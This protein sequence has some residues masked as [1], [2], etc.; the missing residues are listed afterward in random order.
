[1]VAEVALQT[2]NFHSA[3]VGFHFY[4]ARLAVSMSAVRKQSK[5]LLMAL[6]A[7]SIYSF[8]VEFF[9]LVEVVEDAVVYFGVAFGAFDLVSGGEFGC[10][11]LLHEAFEAIKVAKHMVFRVT[12]Q[13]HLLLPSHNHRSAQQT[14]GCFGLVAVRF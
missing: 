8:E 3:H 9:A 4:T 1:V 7:L 5:L 12:V 10:A 6:H 14:R 2:L 13:P 11:A